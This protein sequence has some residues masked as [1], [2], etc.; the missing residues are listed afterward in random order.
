MK[1]IKYLAITILMITAV[2]LL[3]LSTK[4][5]ATTGKISSETARVRK[6][7]ST[8][9]TVLTLLDKGKEIEILKEE[10][11]WYKVEFTEDGKK[12]VGYVSKTLVSASD[13]QQ[14]EETETPTEEPST[15]VSTTNIEVNQ[16]YEIQNE[17]KIKLLPLINSMEKAALN[18]TKIK[19]CEIIND[20]CKIDNGEEVGWIRTN[21][22]RKALTTGEESTTVENPTVETPKEEK[23]SEPVENKKEEKTTVIK[24]GYVSTES[25]KVRKEANTKSEVIDSLTKNAQVSIIEEL[26]GWY[27]IKIG[28]EIGYVSSQYIS[29]KKVETTTSRGSTTRSEEVSQMPEETV[30][31]EEE[32]V[33]SSAPVSGEGESVVEFAKQYLGYKYVAGGASPSKGFDCSGFTSYVYKNFGVSLNRSSRDQVKNGVAVSRSEL[34]PG[35]LV[36]FKGKTGSAIGHVGIYIGGGKFIHASTPSTG[37]IISGLSESYYNT[38]YV[39]ARRVI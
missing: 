8:D 11:G 2:T 38:R 7:A 24:T 39:S 31:E 12:M 4:S 17:V 33:T 19:V 3:I 29:D 6:E 27:K 30:E 25:L 20:W 28:K 36:L 35:D 34:E 15:E 10:N 23:T 16:E 22:L 18:N 13:I 21:I 14:P 37:V 9:S 1:K 5:K 32:P 26:T